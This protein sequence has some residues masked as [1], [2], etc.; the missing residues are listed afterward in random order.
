MKFFWV[1]SAA[2]L[3]NVSILSFAILFGTGV[4]I[5]ERDSINTLVTMSSG[6]GAIYSVKTDKKQISLTF[7]ISWGERQLKPIMDVLKENDV[8]DATFF[9][10]GP[11]SDKHREEVKNIQSMG[12]EI[13]S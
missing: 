13:G 10:S 7:D 12:Y 6:Q 3:K 2:K 5:A 1:I 9:L 4:F 8:K 11:W